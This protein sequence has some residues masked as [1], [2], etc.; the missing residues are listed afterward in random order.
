[1]RRV[2]VVLRVIYHDGRH[3]V[4]KEGWGGNITATL[5]AVVPDRRETQLAPF[6]FHTGGAL[7]NKDM[8]R[9]PSAVAFGRAGTHGTMHK[10]V[11]RE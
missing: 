8:A 11:W 9:S 6:A 10:S 2:R 3:G 7:G 4:Y 5:Y 1:V